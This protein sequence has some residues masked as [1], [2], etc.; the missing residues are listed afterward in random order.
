MIRAAQLGDFEE[1][2]RL[3]TELESGHHRKEA[4]KLHLSAGME[5]AGLYFIRQLEADV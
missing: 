1:V 3:L 5:D 2:A 4:H